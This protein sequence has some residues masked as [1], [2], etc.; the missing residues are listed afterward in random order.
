MIRVFKLY[1]CIMGL[2]SCDSW[3]GVV[4]LFPFVA[5]LLYSDVMSF[6]GSCGNGFVC[7]ELDI[8]IGFYHL[9][10]Q[11]EYFELFWWQYC[12]CSWWLERLVR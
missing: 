1:F 9:S 6:E 11:G 4:V 2:D 8:V 12:Q 7:A 10:S 3:C 5:K